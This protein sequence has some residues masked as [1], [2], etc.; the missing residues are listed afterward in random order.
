MTNL[1]RLTTKEV[2]RICR[3]S[4]ATVKRWDDSGI[5]KSERTSGGHRRFRAEEVVRFQREQELGLKQFHG[6]ESVQM[7]A[8]RPRENKN[9]SNLSIFHSLIAGCEE[10]V[11]NI[12]IS[13]HLDGQPLAKIFDDLICPAM[14]RIGE[15]WYNGELSITKEHLATRVA[16]NA[17]YKLR[18]T[19]P[20]PKMNDQ[21]AICC[22]MESDLHELPTHLVQITLE[23]AG[24]EVINFGANTPFYCLLEEIL[25]H[26]PKL[27]CL[28]GTVLGDIDRLARDYQ[29][30]TEQISKLKIPII[31]GGLVF[32][33]EQIRRRFPAAFYTR[34]FTELADFTAKL[35]PNVPISPPN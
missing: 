28:S 26:L 5:L 34:S 32:A 33:D 31:A 20:V 8:Q 21:L 27:V 23:N 7:A 15:L 11:S 3:V 4:D 6:D 25:Q 24:W 2:A 17:V 13:A 29:Y 19:L 22:A 1:K 10:S 18:S 14:R 9:H 16:Q 30:F 12:L 35:L